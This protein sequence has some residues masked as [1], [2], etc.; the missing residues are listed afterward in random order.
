VL[1]KAEYAMTAGDDI[2]QDSGDEGGD[3]GSA[4]DSE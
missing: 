2:V 4:S 3:G 1:Q